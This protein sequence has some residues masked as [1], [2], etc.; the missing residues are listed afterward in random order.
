MSTTDQISQQL[1]TIAAKLEA[2]DALAADVATLKAQ[3]S[4]NQRGKSKVSQEESEVDSTWKQQETYR[5]PHTK[6]EFSKYEGGDPSEHLCGIQ[7]TGSVFEYRQEVVKRVVR[8][9]NKPEHCLLG[10]FLSGLKEDLR[11]DVRIHKPRSVYKAMSLALEYEGKHRTNQSI[12]QQSSLPN[13]RPLNSEQQ[14]R[15]EKSLCYPCGDKF[16]L[17]H[18][19]KPEMFASLELMKEENTQFPSFRLEDK[20]IFKGEC[21]DKTVALTYEDNVT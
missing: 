16:A 4:Q 7:Q 12:R 8:V 18:R 10:F 14:I 5:R 2:M 1:I 11:L 21:T 15:R 9:Q 19:C 20:A 6:M 3:N 17:G 13:I